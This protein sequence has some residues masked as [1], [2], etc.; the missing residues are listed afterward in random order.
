MDLNIRCLSRKPARR[1]M[2][3]D[4]GVGQRITLT[5]GTG[6]HQQRSHGRGL[7]DAHGRNFRPDVLH[8]V[9]N[10]ETGRHKAT[11]RID[12]KRD[13]LGRVFRFQEQQLRT[14]EAGYVIFHRSYQEDDPLLQEA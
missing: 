12:V 6:R 5:C 7:P 1:L 4:P 14:D 8:R 2:D 3:H 9:V 10:R 11:R 13:V